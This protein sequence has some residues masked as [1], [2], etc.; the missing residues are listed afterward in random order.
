[1]YGRER[2]REA[3]EGGEDPDVRDAHKR[4]EC[5][6]G[7]VDSCIVRIGEQGMRP[8][9]FVQVRV[10]LSSSECIGWFSCETAPSPDRGGRTC[11][12][13]SGARPCETAL[14][15]GRALC[16]MPKRSRSA[17]A[18][19]KHAKTEPIS[20]ALAQKCQN[21]VDDH[22][23]YGR[24]FRGTSVCLSRRES[25]GNLGPRLSPLESW[26]TSLLGTL[27]NS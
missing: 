3:G 7:M 12:E 2:E 17:R 20:A 27:C 25:L 9:F 10:K 16:K 22:G 5:L 1:M 8:G 23:P 6:L 26:S 4:L 13:T 11:G 21:R 14:S 18:L 19:C 24:G 15:R